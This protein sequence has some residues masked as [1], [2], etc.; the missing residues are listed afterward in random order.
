MAEIIHRFTISYG[1]PDSNLKAAQPFIDMIIE[2]IEGLKPLSRDIVGSTGTVE[3][4][5]SAKYHKCQHEL[6]L[7]C[8]AEKDVEKLVI[9]EKVGGTIELGTAKAKVIEPK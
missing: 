1:I 3:V 6:G 8:E 4:T 9:T 7:A 2:G 5:T